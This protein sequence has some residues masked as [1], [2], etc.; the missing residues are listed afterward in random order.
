CGRN[1]VARTNCK[2]GRS[3][4]SDRCPYRALTDMVVFI[5]V[6]ADSRAP[7]ARFDPRRAPQRPADAARRSRR[8][9]FRPRGVGSPAQDRALA[10]T[11]PA[12]DWE[13]GEIG[14]RATSSLGRLAVSPFER[15]SVEA[16]TDP[17]Q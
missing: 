5:E 4:I 3:Q 9:G 15:R 16:L 13:A 11:L 14:L 8:T 10:I 7:E 12:R 6:G 1:E 17:R 2:G